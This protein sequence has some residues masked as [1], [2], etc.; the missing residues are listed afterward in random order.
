MLEL[1]SEQMQKI[2][3]VNPCGF[4]V[5]PGPTSH[6][7][8]FWNKDPKK[9]QR[10]RLLEGFLSFVNYMNQEGISKEQLLRY[11]K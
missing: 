3:D 6:V 2:M 10:I 8:F 7:V 11:L 5:A 4:A 1:T 9:D